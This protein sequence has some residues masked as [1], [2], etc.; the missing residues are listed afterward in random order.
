[1]PEKPLAIATYAL[2]ASLAAISLLYVFGPTFALDADPLASNGKQRRIIGLENPSNLCF[3]NSVLQALANCPELRKYLIKENHRR[4]LDGKGVYTTRL[5]DVEGSGTVAIKNQVRQDNLQLGIVTKALK[6][7]LDRLNERP[8]TR[9]TI[10]AYEF[11]QSLET[12]FNTKISRQQQDAQEFL[13]LVIERIDNEYEGARKARIKYR[14]RILEIEEGASTTTQENDF[15]EDPFPFAGKLE[16]QITCQVCGFEPKPAV[17]AFVT[18]TLNVPQASET[19]LNKC[20]DG[21]LKSET[22]DDFKCD[23]CRLRQIKDYKERKINRTSDQQRHAELLDELSVINETLDT[24]PEKP[25]PTWVKVPNNLRTSK[26]VRSMRVSSYPKVLG[27]HLSRSIY[28]STS[29]STKNNAKVSFGEHLNVGGLQD[30][31]SY[32]LTSVITHKGGHNSGHYETFRRQAPTVPYSTPTTFGSTGPFSVQASPVPSTSN[33]LRDAITPSPVETDIADSTFSILEEEPH[34]I[35][36]RATSISETTSSHR[37]SSLSSFRIRRNI[38][39]SKKLPPTS[40]PV[41]LSNESPSTEPH[42]RRAS[43][44]RRL[45]RRIA[46]YQGPEGDEERKK[47]AKR[48]KRLAQRWWRI[49]D[50]RI[51]ECKTGDLLGMQRE[52]YLLFYELDAPKEQE[53]LTVPNG[54]KSPKRLSGR[55]HLKIHE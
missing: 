46:R 38:S 36:S 44:T 31:R 15:Q 41:N 22:I 33:S 55:E 21:L 6:R 10:N 54:E 3:I 1:M 30:S 49:S 29:Q 9:K 50:D 39:L 24:D 25:L 19:T 52:V 48:R 27:I 45:E 28:S 23:R 51:K 35:P 20:F 4:Q 26:I 2:G 18:L 17:Q 14:D 42:E 11:I 7:M 34:N 5:E 12:A 16:S 53:H 37:S 43:A 32:T 47:L 13:Q 8:L 40:L